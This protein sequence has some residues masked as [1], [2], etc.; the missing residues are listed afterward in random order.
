MQTHWTE[1]RLKRLFDRYN[2]KFWR[3]RLKSYTVRVKDLSGRTMATCDDKLCALFIDAAKHK[4]DREIRATLLHEM[5]HA[6]T[7]KDYPAHGYQFWGQLEMLLRK[8]AP[9]SIGFPEA[10][11]LSRC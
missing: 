11:P 4:T 5:A 3:G 2:R 9:V 7:P 1:A 8:G 10:S 6:A